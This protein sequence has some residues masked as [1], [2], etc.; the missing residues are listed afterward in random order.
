MQLTI[1]QQR[2]LDF[3]D[4]QRDQR[5]AHILLHAYAGAGKSFILTEIAKRLNGTGIYLAFNEA[6][7]SDIKRKLPGHFTAMTTHKLA[8]QQLPEDV[9]KR[10][11]ESLNRDGGR[12]QIPV[13][14]ARIPGFNGPNGMSLA[15][16]A[17]RTIRQF[18]GSV[19][20][21]MSTRHVPTLLPRRIRAD[22]VLHGAQAIWDAMLNFKLPITHDFYFK[23]WTLMNAPIPYDHR[24]MDEAQDTNPALLHLMFQQKHGVSWWAGDPYQSIYSWRGA[25]DA[26]THVGKQKNT[27]ADYLTRSFRFGNAPA[28]L[29]TRLLETLGEKRPVQGTGETAVRLISGESRNPSLFTRQEHQITWL[30]FSNVTLLDVAMN[31]ID[32]GLSFHIVGQGKDEKSL[33]YAAMK[34]KSGKP[35]AKGPLSAYHQWSELEEEAEHYPGGDAS[36]LLRLYRHPGFGAVLDGLNRGTASEADAQ[37][38]LSTAHRAKGRE[39]NCVVID[40]D[41]DATADAPTRSQEKK[42]RRFFVDTDGLHFDNREDIHLRYVAFTRA[43]KHLLVACPVLY[44]WWQKVS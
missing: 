3:V 6:I 32:C 11:R 37:V 15:G 5:V 10:V 9:R 38:V 22:E 18:C 28:A 26:L 40:R 39:W 21:M 41:M 25:V 23:A 12:I 42:K 1:E 19:D 20:A 4:Q 7:V 8:L 14:T 34:L 44:E 17:L 36:H 30:A 29:A 16:F 43:R 13:I 33:I 35:D 31:C 2:V 27:H 24:L